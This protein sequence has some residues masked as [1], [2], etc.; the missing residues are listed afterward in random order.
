MFSE[1]KAV[2]ALF[3]TEWRKKTRPQQGPTLQGSNPGGV[4]PVLRAA[5]QGILREGSDS[6]FCVKGP[7]RGEMLRCAQHDRGRFSAACLVGRVIHAE[8]GHYSQRIVSRPLG[9]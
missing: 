9:E 3:S 6:G 8:I 4:T 7:H 1:E 2:F 5:A